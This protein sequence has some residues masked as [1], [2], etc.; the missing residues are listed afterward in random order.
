MG[1]GRRYVEALTLDNGSGP[2]VQ[3][4]PNVNGAALDRALT[5][6]GPLGAPVVSV[7]G[8]LTFDETVYYG[9]LDATAAVRSANLPASSSVPQG[10]TYV[11][12]KTDASANAVNLVPNGG[13]T[14][15][16]TSSLTTQNAGVIATLDGTTWRTLAFGAG[17]GGGGEDLAAT[18][19]IG[20]NSGP[21]PI[22]MA[23]GQAVRGVD[24]GAPGAAIPGGSLIL[25]PGDGSPGIGAFNVLSV[26]AAITPGMTATVT[27]F[28]LP[29]LTGANGPRTPGGNDFDTTGPDTAVAADLIAAIND[30]A[31]S[32]SGSVTATAGPGPADVTITVSAFSPIFNGFPCA[33]VTVPAAEITDGA[34]VFGGGATPGIPGSVVAGYDPGASA[35]YLGNAS[36]PGATRG[37]NTWDLQRRRSLASQVAYGDNSLMQGVRNRLNTRNSIM[38]G[39]DNLCSVPYHYGIGENAIFGRKMRIVPNSGGGGMASSLFAGEYHYLDANPG[40]GPS[41]PYSYGDYGQYNAFLGANFL[42]RGSYAYKYSA[43][44]MGG[45][46]RN[47]PGYGIL[48]SLVGGFATN[49]S[50][51]F[52][53]CIN[54]S[55][56]CFFGSPYYNQTGTFLFG[57]GGV[58][59]GTVGSTRG[60]IVVGTDHDVIGGYS[61][62]L[63]GNLSNFAVFGGG[64]EPTVNGEFN[65]GARS[66]IGNHQFLRI[67]QGGARSTG[68]G[69]VPL[70]AS[71]NS[72]STFG[73]TQLLV[74]FDKSQAVRITVVGR[75]I[76]SSVPA[77]VG[78]S[79]CW[80][81]TFLAVHVS[82][83]L[84]IGGTILFATSAGPRTAIAPAATA[85]PFVTSGTGALSTATVA[86]T[87]GAS[88]QILVTCT[89]G[90]GPAADAVTRWQCWIDGPVSGG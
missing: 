89:A 46:L 51:P 7:A 54:W 71:L 58:Y 76:S 42:G 14:V 32:Y 67:I 68:P 78:D 86:I 69:S 85:A 12:V 35:N 29:P 56:N 27:I 31:N 1:G 43:F 47:D 48:S 88:G 72:T 40:G 64:C 80:E 22:E 45:I 83:A 19:A 57:E 53:Y 36:V 9:F 17:G 28:G 5:L 79:A 26:A 16:G 87:A 75:I 33:A 37:Q 39:Y 3:L 84:T 44:F 11:I 63:T 66:Q 41:P 30:P 77:E 25:R 65:I 24:P 50:G 60:G 2:P 13:D 82:G 62:G 21:N 90:A 55:R 52:Q 6:G 34:G 23:A 15:T 20:F 18:L 38:V 74:P 81:A 70:T 4:T 73:Q 61:H 59:V 8:D 10:R 49:F